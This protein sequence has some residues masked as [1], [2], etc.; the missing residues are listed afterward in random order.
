MKQCLSPYHRLTQRRPPSLCALFTL[1][2]SPFLR[3]GTASRDPDAFLAYNYTP[4][5]LQRVRV[6]TLSA[7]PSSVRMKYF[8]ANIGTVRLLHCAEVCFRLQCP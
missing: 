7:L 5:A 8:K 1:K 6:Y 2:P 4:A 3:L